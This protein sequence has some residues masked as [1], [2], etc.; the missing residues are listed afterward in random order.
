MWQTPTQSA[1]FWITH[2]NM[3]CR[4]VRK[5]Q[6]NNV[7]IT[8]KN[9]K[10]QYANRHSMKTL[11]KPKETNEEI[12]ASRLSLLAHSF[13]TFG[14]FYSALWL[15]NFDPRWS[16]RPPKSHL[17][18]SRFTSNKSKKIRAAITFW[19]S[20]Q[21]RMDRE[22]CVPMHRFTRITNKSACHQV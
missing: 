15:T 18:H 11:S 10:E 13:V 14:L 1:Q 6:R 17:L 20:R 12:D 9:L 3:T 4:A 22:C 16:Q 7:L 8:M 5:V 21:G 2:N 19:R